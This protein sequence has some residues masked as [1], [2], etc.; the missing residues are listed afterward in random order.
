[1]IYCKIYHYIHLT[2]FSGTT[3]VSWHQKGKPFLVL[4]K[5]EMTGWQGHQLHRMQMICTLHQ[6]YNH[7][8]HLITQVFTSWMPFLIANQ[9]QQNTADRIY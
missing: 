4:M 3:W 8:R 7:A 5:Q 9:Q 1:M 6:V 2:V